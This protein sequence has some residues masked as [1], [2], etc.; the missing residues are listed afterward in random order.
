MVSIARYADIALI[1]AFMEAVLEAWVLQA[2]ES[3]PSDRD[4][5]KFLM[6]YG[7]AIKQ[8]SVNRLHVTKAGGPTVEP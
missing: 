3:A 4:L 6:M 5:D 2:P 1:A 8:R 7:K